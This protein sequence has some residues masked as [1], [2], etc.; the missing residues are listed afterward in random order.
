M[1]GPAHLG[2][3]HTRVEESS[4][5]RYRCGMSTERL[6]PRHGAVH[7]PRQAYLRKGRPDRRAREKTPEGARLNA[8]RWS[9]DPRP[10]MSD[11]ELQQLRE[12]LAST[13]D[14]AVSRPAKLQTA[15]QAFVSLNEDASR[16]PN[17]QSRA[18]DDLNSVIKLLSSDAVKAHDQL[19][20]YVLKMLKIL[21][22]KYD[23]RVRL[24]EHIVDDLVEVCP[25]PT[26]SHDPEPNRSLDEM[27]PSPTPNADPNTDPTLTVT[28]TLTPT[29]T[30]TV[31][32]T[33]TLTLTLTPTP[34]L[35]STLTSSRCCT[36]D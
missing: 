14:C 26:P 5:R 32:V 11:R 28:R 33:P 29:L 31:T 36:S 30:V 15:L 6:E 10:R 4:R 22:R 8:H 17:Y 25:D 1:P 35:T 2:W 19:L 16:S 18:R 34:A 27:Y 24:G 7:H 20:L 21:S 13:P 23:N 3:P 12:L 9:L